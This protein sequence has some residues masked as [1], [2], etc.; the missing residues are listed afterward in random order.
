MSK[1]ILFPLR[2]LHGFLYETNL[3]RKKKRKLIKELIIPAKRIIRE[4]KKVAFLVL[5]PEHGNLGDHAIALS[6]MI[7][8]RRLNIEYIEITG[9][10]ISELRQLKL[11]PFMNGSTILINGGGNLGT[12]W[13]SVELTT[14]EIIKSNPK[15]KIVIFPNTIFYEK[16]E[17]GEKEKNKSVQIY[18]QHQHLQL[19]AR[20]RYSYEIMSQ[21]YNNVSLIPDMV[22]YLNMSQNQKKRAGCL[23]CL[24]SDREK[25]LSD[26]QQNIIVSEA[27]SLFGSDV[28]FTDMCVDHPVLPEERETELN[29]KFDEF[30]SARLVIT[31]RLH[32]MI[33]SAI[34]GTPC[35]V[36]ESKSHKVRGCYEWI[37]SLPYIRF[38]D[39]PED[40]SPLYR[41]I[42][43]EVFHYNPDLFDEYYNSL[44]KQIS[45]LFQVG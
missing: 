3:K 15:S 33:F 23:L 32:G 10:Q 45:D 20:E 18:N 35:I 17:F 11:L 39:T 1:D 41:Q 44:S 13:P 4:K 5:T 28:A 19:Y 34:T 16:T 26:S 8:L 12:L 31:D 27:R 43:D 6:E 2:R 30:L 36:L 9:R 25:T 21:L 40:I 24:R 42:P 14:Q 38:A 7:L 22:L 37:K 29:K